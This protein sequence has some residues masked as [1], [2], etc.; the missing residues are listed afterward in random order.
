MNADGLDKD[1]NVIEKRSFNATRDY[2]WP[3]PDRDIL[4]NPNLEQ[5]PGY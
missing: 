3:F 1:G 5:N 2:L 4:L